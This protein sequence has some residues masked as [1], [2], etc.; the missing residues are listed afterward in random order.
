V[1]LAKVVLK[2]EYDPIP[3]QYSSSLDRCITWLLN[4]DFK[5]RP[6]ISQLIQYVEKKITEGYHGEDIAISASHGVSTTPSLSIDDERDYLSEDSLEREEPGSKKESRKL[7]S[8]D[9]PTPTVVA[10]AARSEPVVRQSYS[11]QAVRKGNSPHRRRKQPI[12]GVEPHSS[13]IAS[14][15]IASRKHND[16]QEEEEED[17]DD[18]E[19]DVDP[20]VTVDMQRVQMLLRRE[21]SQH[22][23]LLQVKNF[24]VDVKTPGLVVA[25][26]PSDQQ[27]SKA[28]IINNIRDSVGKI[29]ILEKCLLQGNM[30]KSSAIRYVSLSK[31]AW[32]NT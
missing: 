25:A 9:P 13:K 26:L 5:K 8:K 30:L 22:R 14:N 11:P 20:L 17:D 1:Q 27:Q 12:D 4:L 29:E 28:S 3:N 18:D 10:A 6:N 15:A 32:G 24:F 31:I 2:G 7:V 21:N 23:K 16:K 19:G